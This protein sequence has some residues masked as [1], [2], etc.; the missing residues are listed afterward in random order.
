MRSSKISTNSS[1]QIKPLTSS[2]TAVYEPT[3]VLDPNLTSSPASAAAAAGGNI[4]PFHP[5]PPPSSDEWDPLSFLSTAD[6][7]SFVDDPFDLP[8]LDLLSP[9]VSA[10]P[11]P[12]EFSRSHLDLLLKA[13]A[14]VESDDAATA[15]VILSRLNQI[16]F[17]CS[18]FQ[19]AAF[20]FKDAL[21]SLL[22]ISNRPSASPPVTPLEIVGRITAQK[23]F[24]DLSPIPQFTSFTANQTLLESLLDP[25][26][27]SQ[28]GIHVIDF[29]IGLGGQW[30][31][32][33]QEIAARS[34]SL[35]SPPPQ[36][37]I[38]AVVADETIETLL[39]AENLRDFGRHIGVHLSVSFVHVGNLG[40]LALGRVRLVAGE[41]VGVVL[42]PA[43]FRLVGGAPEASAALLRFVR[44]V[45]PR[46]VVFV[47]TECFGNSSRFRRSFAGGL[48]FYSSVLE[49][50]GAA[51]EAAGEEEAEVRRI[52]EKVMR[53]RIFGAV[54][55]WAPREGEWR[56][57]L[58]GNGMA[59]AGFSEFTESQ[60][61][62]LLRRFPAEFH[63]ARRE[64]AMVLSWRGRE[65]AATSA[66]R[67]C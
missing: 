22:P 16:P 40:A 27:F 44:Q 30:S 8:D 45:S 37:R 13:A 11:P 7:S 51:A 61:E 47:D 57:V 60:A 14:A 6:A 58:A 21:L 19:R 32:F 66:W 34:K 26:G 33:A 17:G 3:S 50:V 48:E 36:I 25:S 39:A 20:H 9:P 59:A 41:A 31:S 54:A 55:G 63:V 62:W 5:P 28:S 67:C 4:H 10:A 46:I 2:P 49:A 56:E 29:D 52:E 43:I 64:G 15:H 1:P 24:S 35:R 53:P 65:L 23:A 18:P 38:T 12:S 42:T